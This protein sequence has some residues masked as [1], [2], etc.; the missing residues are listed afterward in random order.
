MLGESHASVGEVLGEVS[1][2]DFGKGG[3]AE[4]AWCDWVFEAGVQTYRT[5]TPFLFFITGKQTKM[6]CLGKRNVVIQAH[7]ETQMGYK[8]CYVYPRTPR[9]GAAGNIFVCFLIY[10][11]KKG[12]KVP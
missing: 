12:L 9:P 5:F 7:C 11:S 2:A 1:H 4:I 8:K 10:K 6:L 3:V